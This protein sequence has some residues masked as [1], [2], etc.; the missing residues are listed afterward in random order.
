MGTYAWQI[1]ETFGQRGPTLQRV[2]KLEVGK[3]QWG[4]L[5]QIA[6]AEMSWVSKSGK[7]GFIGNQASN[8]SSCESKNDK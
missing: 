6:I 7:L 3:T 1:A 8:N 2:P 4:W 5:Q